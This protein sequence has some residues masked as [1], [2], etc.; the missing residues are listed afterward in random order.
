M[1]KLQELAVPILRKFKIHLN[2][3]FLINFCRKILFIQMNLIHTHNSLDN[4]DIK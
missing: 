2:L 1:H 4:G 3:R